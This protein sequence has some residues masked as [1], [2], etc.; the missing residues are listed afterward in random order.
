MFAMWLSILHLLLLFTTTMTTTAALSTVRSSGQAGRPLCVL[1]HG[2]G[3]YSGTWKS[4]MDALSSPCLAV[5]QRGCGTSPD[6]SDDSFSQDALVEDLYNLIKYERQ[7]VVLCGHS[8]GGRIA[9]G[10]AAKY[11]ETLAA[12]VIEDMDIQP[13]P[14]PPA[15]PQFGTLFQRRATTREE[16]TASLQS[17]GYSSLRIEEWWQQGR[18][19]EENDGATVWSHVNPDF[20]RLCYPHVLATEY[21]RRDCR[22]IATATNTVPCHVLVA[23]AEGTVCFDDS[24]DEMKTILGDQLTVH[25][26]PDAGHSI[27]NSVPQ[28]FCKTMEEI[29]RTAASS[30]R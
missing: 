12:V 26:Y 7:P 4:T 24:I 9:L 27:H 8:L 11:P 17:H 20:R 1:V 23:G 18:V 21:G 25:R 6:L 28:E 30:G 3:S 19:M 13:R 14:T 15:A 5:D 10:Y 22:T 2:L 29:L 16:L